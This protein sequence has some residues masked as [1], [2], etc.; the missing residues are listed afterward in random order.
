[1]RGNAW[2]ICLFCP[3]Y[4]L[5]LRLWSSLLSLD[6]VGLLCILAWTRSVRFF[7]DFLFVETF[8]FRSES[9]KRFIDRNSVLLKPIHCKILCWLHWFVNLVK[10]KLNLVRSRAYLICKIE[11]ECTWVIYWLRLKLFSFC[12]S[13]CLSLKRLMS[14]CLDIIST[15][16]ELTCIRNG[17]R[18][19][20]VQARLD[21]LSWNWFF[22]QLCRQKPFMNV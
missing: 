14:K 9:V 15:L 7:F 11:I 12:I 19:T 21:P 5:P 2:S 13:S 3:G 18:K 4:H 17:Q 10:A 22:Y 1:M 20:L 8:N 16:K 6:P